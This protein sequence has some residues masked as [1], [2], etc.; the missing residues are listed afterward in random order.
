M[1]GDPLVPHPPVGCRSSL[2]RGAHNRSVGPA[3]GASAGLHRRSR[4]PIGPGPRRT[5]PPASKVPAV[6]EPAP[7]YAGNVL[8]RL[9]GLESEYESVLIQLSDPAVI[10]DQRRLRDASRRHK[11]LEP[12]VAAFREYRAVAADLATAR[13]MLADLAA[14]PRRPNGDSDPPQPMRDDRAVLR[15]EMDSG[16]DPPA[17]TG[18]AA[19]APPAAHGP[20]RRQE[21]HHRDPRRRGRRGG[22]P[23][24]P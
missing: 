4:T 11:E 5:Q 1:Q 8:D 15:Q 16:R 6:R 7:R 19:Q 3:A 22:E 12:V 21:R 13:E 24:C 23:V 17:R 10:S 20:Q 2:R 14:A 9:S 18:R